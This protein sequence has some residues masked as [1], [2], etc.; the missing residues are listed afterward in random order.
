MLQNG[1]KVANAYLAAGEQRWL[2]DETTFSLAGRYHVAAVHRLARDS[3]LDLFGH[4]TAGTRHDFSGQLAVLSERTGGALGDGRTIALEHTLLRYYLP[5]QTAD[6]AESA[7]RALQG[8]DLSRLKA[9]LGLLSSRFRANHPLKA[10]FACMAQ[11]RRKEGVAYWRLAH[12]CPGVWYC[13]R[14]GEPLAEFKLKSNGIQRFNLQLPH[15][16]ALEVWP[17]LTSKLTCDVGLP[18]ARI[19]ADLMAE[20]P[21]TRIPRDRLASAYAWALETRYGADSVHAP[22]C[23][24]VIA[25]LRR[26]LGPLMRTPGFEALPSSDSGATAQLR[27]LLHPRSNGH[28]VWHLLMT[29]WL[30]G[31]WPGLRRAIDASSIHRPAER[32]ARAIER[33]LAALPRARQALALHQSGKSVRAIATALDVD[34]K[35]ASV[36]L[37]KAGIATPRRAKLLKAEIRGRAIAA[38]EGGAEKLCVATD[39]QVSV[40]TITHLLRSEPGL[41]DK[42]HAAIYRARRNVARVAWT[43]ALT[44]AG[45]SGVKV[46]RSLASADFA[47]LYRN[48]REW[49]SGQRDKTTAVRSRY[50]AQWSHRDE[51]ACFEV[52]AA[53]REIPAGLGSR[54]R[55]E[56]LIQ[57][58]PLLE[59]FKGKLDK[60]PLTRDIVASFTRTGAH[61]PRD[62]DQA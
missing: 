45:D 40:G 30:F 52:L 49:L 60:M 28:P 29:H 19:A 25:D 22:S 5:F 23:R 20:R 2:P 59:R 36:W 46:A 61:R 32:E 41:R 43:A 39:A 51:G 50:C 26:L 16:G 3:S 35:T 7:I 31:D 9:Q 17:A 24:S 4:P 27:R 57:M 10:C 8:A 44:K 55:R 53:I 1:S 33:C 34:H 58:S 18:L 47:W 37:A 6:F 11:D 48:D 62:R 21:D 15:L 42:W 13:V 54:G 56:A 38:L 12:Q 14:H